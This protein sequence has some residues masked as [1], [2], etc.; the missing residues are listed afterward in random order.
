[1]TVYTYSAYTEEV[2][3]RKKESRILI[4]NYFNRGIT[5]DTHCYIEPSCLEYDAPYVTN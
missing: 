5:K 1:M 3:P 4:S 2:I